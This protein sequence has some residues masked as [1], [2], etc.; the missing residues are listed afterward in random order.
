MISRLAE[1]LQPSKIRAMFH[2]ALT[3][4][5]EKI[6]NL[7]LGEPDFSTPQEVIAAAVQAMHS[8]QT[9]YTPN[10]GT[11]DLRRQIAAAV[12]AES[13]IKLDPELE[14]IVTEGG[15]AGLYLSLRTLLNPGDEVLLPRPSWTNYEA[16]IALAGGRLVSVPMSR[17]TGFTPDPEAIEARIT[18]RTKLLILNS[19]ANPT[20]AVCDLPLLE[21]IAA[22][23][24]RHDFL[25][26]SDEV[27]KHM[28]W[29]GAQHVSIASL[30]DMFRRTI[31]INS[32]S[33]TYAMT[34][35]RI[36]YTFGPAEV[37]SRMTVMQE[38]V[39][40]CPNSL[41]Q[42]GAL[43]ALQHDSCMLPMLAAFDE[44]RR[45]LTE[46]LSDIDGLSFVPPRGAFYL[47]LDISRTGLASDD[48]ALRLLREGGV[49]LVPGTA[50]GP[51]GEGYLRISYAASIDQL[52]GAADRIRLFMKSL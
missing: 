32:F 46:A 49:C 39:Y 43:A 21:R 7:A 42:A 4:D 41:S 11:P 3:M 2:L 23:A 34:G 20:G 29:D 9:H 22:L 45:I 12:S 1:E 15:M 31:T 25:V 38:D 19:P 40:S 18:P 48:F 10:S 51:E 24:V 5:A 35:W 17:E 26:I 36:G 27:Y 28:I 13:G 44:R 16:Q 37:I 47:F 33:K 14:I 8:G 50:F 30:P 52:L 6:I